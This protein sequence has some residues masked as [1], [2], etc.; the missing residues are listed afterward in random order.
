MG[1]SIQSMRLSTLHWTDRSSCVCGALR[2]DSQPRTRTGRVASQLTDTDS[3]KPTTTLEGL[4]IREQPSP[5]T[6]AHSSSRQH[7]K[8]VPAHISHLFS[9]I[10]LFHSTFLNHAS[11]TA[12]M[13]GMKN[14][15]LPEL[16]MQNTT[17]PV[18]KLFPMVEF[19]FSVS[20]RRAVEREQ[21]PT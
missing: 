8:H 10:K 21:I 6:E 17:I 1:S 20:L 5:D 12:P 13:G 19:F 2:A 7:Q 4:R 9:R 14:S 16:N 15:I 18:R 3:P 11:S